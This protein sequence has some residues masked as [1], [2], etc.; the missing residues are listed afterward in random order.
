MVLRTRVLKYWVLGPLGIY[1]VF[2]HFRWFEFRTVCQGIR[3]S[4][5]CRLDTSPV[6]SEFSVRDQN[7]SFPRWRRLLPNVL[8][9]IRCVGARNYPEGQKLAIFA[10]HASLYPHM[11]NPS[12]PGMQ[13]VSTWSLLCKPLNCPLKGARA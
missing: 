13:H 8:G 1:Q 3:L 9:A 6:T 5:A 4:R 10:G 7:G 11:R 12:R 2:M